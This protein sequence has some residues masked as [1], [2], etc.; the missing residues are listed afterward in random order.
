MY[1]GEHGIPL[2]DV[3]SYWVVRLNELLA[4]ER[5]WHVDGAGEPV[6]SEAANSFIDFMML[7]EC[8]TFVKEFALF[9]SPEGGLSLEGN[10]KG[11]PLHDLQI[12]VEPDGNF[13]V[14]VWMV[15]GDIN[16]V[17]NFLKLDTICD[18]FDV[19]V[20]VK[21]INDRFGMRVNNIERAFPLTSTPATSYGFVHARIDSALLNFSTPVKSGRVE[22]KHVTNY[23]NSVTFDVT[24]N[25]MALFETLCGERITGRLQKTVD[26]F[27]EVES[28][29]GSDDWGGVHNCPECLKNGAFLIGVQS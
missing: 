24:V 5:G 7:A 20:A 8:E 1:A 13:Y 29:I 14:D 11:E 16:I 3:E 17:S 27:V 19:N 22:V 4:I 18:S 6:T 2:T 28:L 25:N 12:E 15:Q 26:S 10:H 21:S 9:P 23:V